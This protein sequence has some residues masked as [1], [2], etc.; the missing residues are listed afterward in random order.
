M[1][2][3]AAAGQDLAAGKLIVAKPELGDPNFA[4]SVILLI[5]YDKDKGAVGLILNRRTKVPIS[6]V[7]PELKAP[8]SDPVFLGGPVETDA[9]QAL[10]RAS[11]K[12]ADANHVFADVYAT[13]K[14]D[15]IDKSIAAG[16]K[17]SRFRIYVGYGGWAPGQL[18][19][20]TELGAWA[21]I[22][23]TPEVVFDDDPDSLWMRMNRAT[24]TRIALLT[25]R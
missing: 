21:V 11:S 7:F 12:P 13:G 22:R 8:V 4:E 14:K 16:A 6:R 2:L 15:V 20:E 19:H 10:M 1:A 25:S 23:A 3:G 18:E 24:D 17:A 9:A 5:D